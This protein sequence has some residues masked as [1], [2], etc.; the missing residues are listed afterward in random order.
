LPELLRVLS[1]VACYPTHDAV[2]VPRILERELDETLGDSIEDE[3]ETEI[4][5]ESESETETETE[6][7]KR[8]RLRCPHQ[9][10]KHKKASYTKKNNMM[11]H[12]RSREF[13][14]S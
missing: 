3:T 13:L 5:S 12:Y 10:C 11:R 7:G 1:N 4:E 9:E 6:T 14:L 2:E 8:N